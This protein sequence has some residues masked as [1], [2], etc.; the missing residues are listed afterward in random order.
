MSF[1]DKLELEKLL[2]EENITDEAEM[3]L[4]QK[5]IGLISAPSSEVWNPSDEYTAKALDV[6]KS[7]LD[8]QTSNP[9]YKA[10]LAQEGFGINDIENA[11]TLFDV[12]NNTHMMDLMIFRKLIESKDGEMIPSHIPPLLRVFP[13]DRLYNDWNSSATGENPSVVHRN[14]LGTHL[15]VAPYLNAF[16]RACEMSSHGTKKYDLGII[17][18]PDPFDE[19][20]PVKS[21]MAKSQFGLIVG[22]L[23]VLCEEMYCALDFSGQSGPPGSPNV[24]EVARLL[25][26][27][28]TEGKSVC[29]G[30]SPMGIYGTLAAIRQQNGP[31]FQYDNI[32]QLIVLDGGGG[33]ETGK[34][35]RTKRDPVELEDF[36]GLIMGLFPNASMQDIFSV[37]GTSEVCYNAVAEYVLDDNG[38]RKIF[39]NPGYATVG[40]VDLHS[41]QLS[42]TGE[43]LL[44][45]T[46]ALNLDNA[47]ANVIVTSDIVKVWDQHPFTSQKG[48]YWEY[49]GRASDLYP[50]LFEDRKNGC[51]MNYLR[52][53]KDI[54]AD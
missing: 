1:V 36:V 40:V 35:G 51:G 45:I 11:S 4:A 9:L 12:G 14:E 48:I 16:E 20:E 26:E 10:M 24:K 17:F 53:A 25:E 49:I 52:L 13:E 15:M 28:N 5:Q 6:L 23:D 7:N 27:A 31:D 32:N 46:T 2:E 44:A 18:S 42:E 33:L 21:I 39:H 43:S 38:V 3:K 29:L 8:W 19:N 50:K 47:G 37:Y 22:H 54:Q 30:A 34:K 41:E